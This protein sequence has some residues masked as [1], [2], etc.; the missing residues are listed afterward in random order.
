ME[1]P[2]PLRHIQHMQHVLHLQHFKNFL[3]IS[4]NLPNLGP[5]ESNRDLARKNS[6]EHSAKT[7]RETFR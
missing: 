3:T 6:E 4:E 2:L 5:Q 7:F 1:N